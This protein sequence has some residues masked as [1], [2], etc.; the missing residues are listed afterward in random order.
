MD[1]LDTLKGPALYV[2]GAVIIAIVGAVTALAWNGNL[3]GSDALV[4]FTGILTAVTGV[5]AVAA[6]SHA[7]N[8][9]TAQSQ[10]GQA[11]TTVTPPPAPTGSTEPTQVV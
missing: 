9:A 1:M 5:G 8:T 7:V 11:L 2:A 6:T 10:S 3:S 4:V